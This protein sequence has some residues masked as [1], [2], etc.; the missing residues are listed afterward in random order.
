MP[1]AS[2]LKIFLFG[3]LTTQIIVCFH[4]HMLTR[5]KKFE[6]SNFANLSGSARTIMTA[7]KMR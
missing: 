5:A 1:A 2:G 6:F 4:S 7:I 3:N